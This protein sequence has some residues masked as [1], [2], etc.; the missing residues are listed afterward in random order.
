MRILFL[1]LNFPGQFR[2]IAAALGAEGH[3]VA[4]LCQTHYGRELAGV[5]RLCMKGNLGHEALQQG[6]GNQLQRA[7]RAAKQYRRA[8]AK[9]DGEGWVPDVV[10]SH[11]GWGCGL[12][13]KE[14]W[15]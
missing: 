8:M 1:H 11:S 2:H 9:L 3:D 10:V 12:H 5:R 7:Q 14:L 6:G 4:F 13:V 15:P